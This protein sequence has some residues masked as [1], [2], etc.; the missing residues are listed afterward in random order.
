MVLLR[1]FRQVRWRR[2]GHPRPALLRR[3]TPPLAVPV[4]LIVSAASAATKVACQ[5]TLE[6]KKGAPQHYVCIGCVK[7]GG[8]HAG[9]RGITSCGPRRGRAT[10]PGRRRASHPARAQAGSCCGAGPPVRSRA[11]A[12]RPPPCQ[13]ARQWTP[14]GL[15]PRLSAPERQKRSGGLQGRDLQSSAQMVAQMVAEQ[16]LARNSARS[17]A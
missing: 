4:A 17:V 13:T 15:C 1:R 2:R 10:C 8:N 12:P 16:Q 14:H 9:C 11:A 6:A 3:A 5:P 7:S